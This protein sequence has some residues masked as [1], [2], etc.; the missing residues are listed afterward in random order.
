[1]VQDRAIKTLLETLAGHT[2]AAKRLEEILSSLAQLRTAAFEA[3]EVEEKKWKRKYDDQ[4]TVIKKQDEAIKTFKEE[5][6][7]LRQRIKNL[8]GTT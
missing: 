5:T 6:D 1:M 4:D 2:A 7:T 3:T 8:L